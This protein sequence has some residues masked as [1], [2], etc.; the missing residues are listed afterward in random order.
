MDV[1]GNERAEKITGITPLVMAQRKL[2]YGTGRMPH[3]SNYLDICFLLSPLN[4]KL[5][6]SEKHPLCLWILVNALHTV[7]AVIYPLSHVQPFCD[8]MDCSPPGSPAHGIFQARNTGVGC[9]FFPQGTFMT[10]GSNPHLLWLLHWQVY[11]L[12]LSHLRN[13]YIY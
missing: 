3:W 2:A 7:V 1:F 10:Q 5:L 11:S 4:C 8:P 6:K 12:P 13:P 9:H